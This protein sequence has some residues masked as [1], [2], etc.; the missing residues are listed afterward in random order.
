[1]LMRRVAQRFH[2]RRGEAGVER[3][4]LVGEGRP[5]GGVHE[6]HEEVHVVALAERH[7]AAGQ[8]RQAVG[9]GGHVGAVARGVLGRGGGAAHHGHAHRLLPAAEQRRRLGAHEAAVE[10]DVF[11]VECDALEVAHEVRIG[12]GSVGGRRV[13]AHPAA[14]GQVALDGGVELAQLLAPEWHAP[15]ARGSGGAARATPVR[16]GWTGS[17]GLRTGAAGDGEERRGRAETA[18]GRRPLPAGRRAAGLQPAVLPARANSGAGHEVPQT[19]PPMVSPV[20]VVRDL[21]AGQR[22]LE[23]AFHLDQALLGG[24]APG[25]ALVGDAQASPRSS[26]SGRRSPSRSPRCR[27][28]RAPS[29]CGSRRW[30]C[31]GSR[32]SSSG[33]RWSGRSPP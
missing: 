27:R 20:P 18:E 28:R 23:V 32:R 5:L 22:A 14:G 29:R 3:L 7:V 21:A 24:G 15:S 30:R 19:L 17:D 16:A 31:A 6:E 1:M 33:A 25:L 9:E 2:H 8:V 11:V 26:R 12:E 10:V 4:D 13:L